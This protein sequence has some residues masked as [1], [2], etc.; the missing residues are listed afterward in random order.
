MQAEAA[1]AVAVVA[2]PHRGLVQQAVEH[3]D[4]GIGVAQLGRQHVRMADAGALGGGIGHHF[5]AQL[6]VKAFAFDAAPGAA[7][8][9]AAGGAELLDAMD[10]ELVEALFHGAAD[11]VQGAELEAVQPL[12]QF[13]LA[14]HD[15]AVGLLHVGRGLGEEAV[16]RDADRA[17]QHVADLVVD[18]LLD[19]LAEPDGVGFLALAAHQVAGHFVDGE[20]GADRRARFDRGDDA[21]VDFDVGGR[22]RLH[23]DDVLAQLPGLP[24]RGAGTDAEALG[25]D[26]GGDAAGGVGHHRQHA[27]RT[28]AQ[29]GPQL[30][31]G[32]GEEGIEVDVK[33]MQGHGVLRGNTESSSRRKSG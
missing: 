27:D 19:L 31:L 8:G 14:D 30:L 1:G 9:V 23:E 13:V 10:A 26:A 3:G 7:Q 12:R 16:G 24:H 15:E 4:G 17:V 32:R 28:A 29:L 11:A 6:G 21:M 25:V 33:R 5:A 20:H 22:P 18:R 2:Q